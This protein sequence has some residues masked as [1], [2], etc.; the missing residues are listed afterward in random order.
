MATV[1]YRG[2]SF[3]T[4]V[5]PDRPPGAHGLCATRGRIALFVERSA[6]TLP[7]SWDLHDVL[8][9]EIDRLMDPAA[10]RHVEVLN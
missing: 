10:L 9:Y 7:P 3:H 1:S 4:Y 5:P 8:R 6:G 2:F